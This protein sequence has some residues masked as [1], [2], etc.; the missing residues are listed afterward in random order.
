MTASR[1][2]R[3]LIRR[4]ASPPVTTS[5]TRCPGD[6]ASSTATGASAPSDVSRSSA[7]ARVSAPRSPRIG[8]EPQPGLA[9]GLDQDVVEQLEIGTGQRGVDVA[10]RSGDRR[11]RGRGAPAGPRSPAAGPTVHHVP[12]APPSG[13]SVRCGG[14]VHRGVAGVEAVR[15][16]PGP[17]G[18][19]RRPGLRAARQHGRQEQPD[20]HDDGDPHEHEYALEEVHRGK[21]NPTD[22]AHHMSGRWC[23]H[24]RARSS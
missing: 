18:L 22:R 23:R 15:V 6:T 13:E 19:V 1:A 17:T 24:G 12:R 20:D 4:D 10:L 3:S 5:T 8:G 11:S 2:A 9:L 21:P 14:Y 16:V 7:V